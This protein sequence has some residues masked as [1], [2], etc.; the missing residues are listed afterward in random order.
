MRVLVMRLLIFKRGATMAFAGYL[1]KVGGT[2]FP[3]TYVF[4]ESYKI[5]TQS[6]IDLDSN[7]NANGI[8]MR[9]VL[10]HTVTKITMT[11]RPMWNTDL[12]AMMAILNGAFIN[13]QE[14]KVNA[15]YYNPLTDDY[16]SGVFYVPDIEPKMNLV[17]LDNNRILYNSFDIKLIEY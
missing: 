7:R 11:T 3:L 6:R 5:N 14:R 9:N 4:K 12:S 1:L 13:A 10:E 8:L 2:T 17:D 15:I 16:G